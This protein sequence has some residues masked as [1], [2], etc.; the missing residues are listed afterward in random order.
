MTL[1]A[2]GIAL[3]RLLACNNHEGESLFPRRSFLTDLGLSSA[4]TGVEIGAAQKYDLEEEGSVDAAMAVLKE[5]AVRVVISIGL[6]ADTSLLA[7]AAQKHGML[8]EGYVWLKPDGFSPET[9]V[10]EAT[11]PQL[12]VDQMT[13]W[14]MMDMTG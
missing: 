7:A 12:A 13:G 9:Y 14:L 4:P 1:S 6:D 2:G 3:L 8:G 11:D 5:S 10:Q